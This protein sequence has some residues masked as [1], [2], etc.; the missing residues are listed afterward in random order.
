MDRLKTNALEG[1]KKHNVVGFSMTLWDEFG[2]AATRSYGFLDA[3]GREPVQAESRFNACSISKMA[4]A[5]LA[6]KLTAEGRIGLDDPVNERLQGWKCQVGHAGD[7]GRITLRQLLSHHSGIRDGEDSFDIGR[8]DAPPPSMT[9][10]LRGKTVYMSQP[11]VVGAEPGGAFHYSDAGYCV[12]QKYM[13]DCCGKPFDVLMSEKVLEPLGMSLS[14]Y[15][16]SL[17]IAAKSGYASGHDRT[18]TRTEPRYP[19]YPFAAAAGLWSTPSDLAKLAMEVIQ[20]LRGTG[21]L[22]L[23]KSLVEEMLTPQGQTDFAGLGLFLSGQEGRRIVS[24]YGWG[25]GF[26]SMMVFSPELGKGAALMQNTDTGRHQREGLIGE[27]L[28]GLGWT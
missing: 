16:S 1:M 21:K 11:I 8:D 13:E 14:S 3:E 15:E 22:G 9:D 20:S 6:M 23:S 26:Q 24:S 18:G 7:E 4:A 25:V 12:A 17:S 5:L 2:T 10:I 19:C 27:M 28:E